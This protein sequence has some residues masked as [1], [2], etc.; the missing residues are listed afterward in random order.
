[1]ENNR[2]LTTRV[3]AG[4]YYLPIGNLVMVKQG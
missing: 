1:M 2:E 4:L 3:K